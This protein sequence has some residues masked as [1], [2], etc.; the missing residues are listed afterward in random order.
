MILFYL[1]I[2]VHR[3]CEIATIDFFAYVTLY[4]DQ[5]NFFVEAVT[6]DFTTETSTR[7]SILLLLA[8]SFSHYLPSRVILLPLFLLSLSLSF[9]FI[10]FLSSSRGLSLSRQSAY[11]KS[12]LPSYILSQHKVTHLCGFR[13][14]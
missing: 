14:V 4:F 9:L 13:K 1:E 12:H 5:F 8:L 6:V 11:I 10:V 2:Y 7:I 3:K